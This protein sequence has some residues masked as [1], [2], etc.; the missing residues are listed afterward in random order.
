MDDIVERHLYA[1]KLN[2]LP[3]S[4]YTKIQQKCFIETAIEEIHDPAGE[5][6][7]AVVKLYTPSPV[8]KGLFPYQDFYVTIDYAGEKKYFHVSANNAMEGKIEDTSYYVTGYF[9]GCKTAEEA[10]AVASVVKQQLVERM[11]QLN[12]KGMLKEQLLAGPV[13]DH[14]LG[15]AVHAHATIRKTEDG[16]VYIE[17]KYFLPAWPL[18]PG[19]SI[20]SVR[21]DFVPVLDYLLDANREKKHGQDWLR[22]VE[23][24]FAISMELDFIDPVEKIDDIGAL[25]RE[26]DEI[27]SSDLQGAIKHLKDILNKHKNSHTE[28]ELVFN[29]GGNDVRGSIKKMSNMIPTKMYTM[30]DL[31]FLS[32]SF[33]RRRCQGNQAINHKQCDTCGCCVKY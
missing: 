3:L 22:P 19:S 18:S 31:L 8:L 29:R 17:R 4:E 23:T 21:K 24:S 14:I 1:Y 12:E 7:N 33:Q 26:Y 15:E 16:K 11:N 25:C 6:F 10:S 28:E 5:P 27:I 13:S 32:L 20:Y 9:A 30:Q 2:E